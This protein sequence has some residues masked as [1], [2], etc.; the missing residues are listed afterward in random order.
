MLSHLLGDWSDGD[1]DQPIFGLE[2][3]DDVILE[4]ME[5]QEDV[6]EFL[7]RSPEPGLPMAPF[8]L[9]APAHEGQVAAEEEELELERL[10]RT[11]GE[12]TL[13]D[14]APTAVGTEG[15]AH[16]ERNTV[17]YPIPVIY[18]ARYS[19]EFDAWMQQTFAGDE[20]KKK[21]ARCMLMRWVY[22]YP[23]QT[24]ARFPG[25][26][27][28]KVPGLFLWDP[29]LEYT[30][31]LCKRG[32]NVDMLITLLTR[33]LE[34]NPDGVIFATPTSIN[35]LIVGEN[36]D[37]K[38]TNTV[39]NVKNRHLR[40]QNISDTLKWRV[41]L[42]PALERLN[43]L[44]GLAAILP[45]NKRTLRDV[46][47][48]EWN[49]LRA[50]QEAAMQ[51]V[52]GREIDEIFKDADSIN[53]YENHVQ[54]WQ[55]EES[56][57]CSTRKV[58][59]KQAHKAVPK[60]QKRRPKLTFAPEAEEEA[61]PPAPQWNSVAEYLNSQDGQ[62]GLRAN[63]NLS[64]DDLIQNLQDDWFEKLGHLDPETVASQ[65]VE[66]LN[67]GDDALFSDELVEFIDYWD[68]RQAGAAAVA[69]IMAMKKFI[70]RR[71]Q[72]AHARKVQARREEKA[73]RERAERRKRIR[74]GRAPSPPPLTLAEIRRKRQMREENRENE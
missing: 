32:D 11:A 15:V 53:T 63:A 16:Y 59:E 8:Q 1:G 67:L 60:T 22:L 35:Y 26:P 20:E 65:L 7:F 21:V 37:I 45:K 14:C 24:T 68:R 4:P 40:E 39:Y 29:V 41:I 64:L 57:P 18:G 66:Y 28:T 52:I 34:Q 38:S 42:N 55:I 71:S 70:E 23:P 56:R 72:E 33:N 6:E 13:G 54:K 3:L 46:T 48:I 19:P 10:L 69:E 17:P 73:A 27:E 5:R 30:M 9:P 62:I 31:A 43:A 61:A 49:R 58:A 47:S 44:P 2:D 12:L 36:R 74:E 50:Q 25:G 51:T